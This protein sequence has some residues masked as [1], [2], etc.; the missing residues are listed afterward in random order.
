VGFLTDD[1][2]KEFDTNANHTFWPSRGAV[3][4]VRPMVNYN[5][6]ESQ[7]GVLRS[8]VL[9]NRLDVVFRN[10]AE[11]RLEDGEEFKLF[12]KEFRNER[13]VLTAGW[14]GRDGRSISAYVGSG[15]NFE[16]DLRLY[17]AELGW[18]VGD[19]WRFS[20]AATRLRLSPDLANESTSIHVFEMLYSFNPDLFVRLFVQTNSSIDKENVQALW[21]WRFKPPFGS[22]QI[23][24]QRG[25][26]A[27]GQPSQQGDSLFTKLA[28]VF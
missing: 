4:R 18:P 23:A 7:E 28:W 27:Q 26:S 14:N 10:G 5:R 3:E 16:N 1:D 8:W 19:R 17:G 6:Y 22:L 24:Y 21:V 15:F 12:E 25:T 2:R 9:T 11:T 20:Y 13:T